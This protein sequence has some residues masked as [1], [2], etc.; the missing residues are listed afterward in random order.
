[1]KNPS[2]TLGARTQQISGAAHRPSERKA[3]GLSAK[4]TCMRRE[5]GQTLLVSLEPPKKT[6]RGILEFFAAPATEA[7]RA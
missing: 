3:P 4:S 7:C 5:T 6:G 1:M 2:L